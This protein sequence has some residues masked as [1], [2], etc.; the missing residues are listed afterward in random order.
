[1]KTQPNFLVFGIFLA[2]L[3]SGFGQSTLQFSAS[4][5]TVAENAATATLSVRRAT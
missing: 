2:A 1:M 3:G 5:Y 4:T